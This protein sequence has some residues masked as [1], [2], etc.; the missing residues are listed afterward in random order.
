MVPVMAGM[1]TY[2][3]G[4]V[5]RYSAIMSTYGMFGYPEFEP[6]Y[7]TTVMSM[8]NLVGLVGTLL[9][10]Y[11]GIKLRKKWVRNVTFI[12]LVGGVLLLLT[13]S[14]LSS[15][16]VLTGSILACIEQ[17]SLLSSR[18]NEMVDPDRL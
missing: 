10:I 13:F 7:L 16:L 2:G 14:W 15:L 6:V 8:W 1:I 18:S 3:Y 11:C 17:D 12:G 4:T 5:W 9:S